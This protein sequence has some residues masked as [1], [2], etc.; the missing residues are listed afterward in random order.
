[1]G[2]MA[3]TVLMEGMVRT[4]ALQIIPPVIEAALVEPCQIQQ[5][6]SI[7]LVQKSY[8]TLISRTQLKI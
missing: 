6:N 4:E 1:M 5:E 3:E 7:F 2:E 8:V